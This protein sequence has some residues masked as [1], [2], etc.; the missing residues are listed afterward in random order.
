MERSTANVIA[1]NQRI[2][3]SISSASTSSIA[4]TLSEIRTSTPLKRKS[5]EVADINTE[6]VQTK[7]VR[8][9]AE[10]SEIKLLREE[11]LKLISSLGGDLTPIKT[12]TGSLSI[13]LIKGKINLEIRKPFTND[14]IVK[15]INDV[16][17][18]LS[19]DD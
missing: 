15:M 18:E 5:T 13:K 6:T 19:D 10:S 17:L 16:A 12:K 9:V 7:K 4:N 3:K 1:I 11:C 14:F 2:R 8:F